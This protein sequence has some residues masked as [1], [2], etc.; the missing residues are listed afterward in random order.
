MTA[1]IASLAMYDRPALRAANDALWAAIAARLRDDRVEGVPADLDRGRP[2][3]NI[4]AS[5]GLLL[6]QCCGFPLVTT[7]RNRLQVVAIPRYGATDVQGAS[8]HSV[9]VVRRGDPAATLADLRMRRAALNGWDSNTGHNLFRSVI[10]PLAAGE[11][12]FGEVAVTGSHEMTARFIADGLADVGAI[13]AVSYAH[14]RRYNPLLAAKLRVLATTP[15]SPNLPFV[16]SIATSP[17]D[18]SAL[19]RALSDVVSDVRLAEICRTLLLEGF[20]VADADAYAPVA[21]LHAAAAGLGYP[22]LH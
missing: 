10:A 15:S 4:W 21:D 3:D 18:L 16:T 19:R 17:A 5:P 1:R 22:I 6:A 7:Y 14:L 8:H 9:I 20:D 11:A 12:F 2:L 13:D